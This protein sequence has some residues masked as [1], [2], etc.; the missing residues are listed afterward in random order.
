MGPNGS[1]KTTILRAMLNLIHPL[2]GSVE[3][4]KLGLRLGYVPQRGS[5]D[6][7]WPLRVRDVVVMGLY[8]RVG[9]FRRPGKDD[10]EAADRA[11]EAVGIGRLSDHPFGPLS[12]GQKQRALIARALVTRPDVLCFDEPT[13]GMDLSGSRAILALIE[14]LHLSGITIVFVTHQLN[15]VVNSSVR[16]GLVTAGSLS[17]GTTAEMITPENLG[18]LYGI[19]V[20]VVDV[21]GR[22][23]V[24][25]DRGE[26]RV[27]DQA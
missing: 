26:H 5:L 25:A 24:L 10:W 12:G 4:L 16:I 17:V 11:M 21:N 15:D 1:G 2:C 3:R 18:R 20:Q 23:L 6:D 22:R 7:T 27:A 13:S 8:G 14:D 9:L 19:P